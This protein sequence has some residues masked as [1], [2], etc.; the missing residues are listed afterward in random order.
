LKTTGRR[1]DIAK[2]RPDGFTD[3]ALQ[4]GYF[5]ELRRPRRAS[6]EKRGEGAAAPS[7]RLFGRFILSVKIRVSPRSEVF[8]RSKRGLK[9]RAT[10]RRSPKAGG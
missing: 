1:W 3:R 9:R 6:L 8:R 7:N 2:R 4:P 5:M 10:R